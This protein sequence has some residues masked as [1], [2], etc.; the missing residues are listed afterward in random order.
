[1]NNRSFDKLISELKSTITSYD[2]Y[3]NFDKV[4]KEVKDVKYNLNILNHL[5]GQKSFDEEFKK[6]LDKNP[7]VVSVL[8]ILLAVREN[9]LDILDNNVI[10]S[11]DFKENMD[12][13]YY[14]EFIYKTRL[15]ELFRDLRIKNFVDYV[16]GIEVGLDT[17]GRKN[18][19]GTAMGMLVEKFVSGINDTAWS[20]E[21][22]Q[23]K[24]KTDLGIEIDEKYFEYTGNKRFDFVL[25]SKNNHLFLIETNFY[26]TSGSKLNETSRSYIKLAEDLKNVP[27]VTFVWITD[28]LGWLKTKNNLKDAYNKIEYVFNVSDLENGLLEELILNK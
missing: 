16:T 12:K 11:Y 13:N 20:K 3:V 27:N 19:S 1:M 26:R 6:M 10:V 2:Y 22:T 24:I 25:K 15:I 18:R 21:A 7:D 9:K 8:P 4:F 28:G 5:I 14:L 17:N 23:S